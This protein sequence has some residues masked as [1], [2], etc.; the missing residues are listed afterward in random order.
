MQ[1]Q[2]PR[3]GVDY[4]GKFFIT[5]LRLRLCPEP[6]GAV[7]VVCVVL[8]AGYMRCIP[9]YLDIIFHLG[10]NA[11]VDT[12]LSVSTIPQWLKHCVSVSLLYNTVHVQMGSFSQL[13]LTIP[14]G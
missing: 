12:C 10:G 9:I 14:S 6:H 8:D 7:V 5:I 3:S 13:I 4:Y 11:I 1:P 2:K